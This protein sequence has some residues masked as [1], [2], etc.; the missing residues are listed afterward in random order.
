MNANLDLEGRLAD[1]YASE[2][3]QRSPDRVLHEA[4]AAIDSTQQRRVLIPAPWRF[5]SMNSYAKVAVVAIAVIAFG[6]V[7]MAVLRPN[8]IAG[9]G[10]TAPPSPIPT[11][12][13]SPEASSSFSATSLGFVSGFVRPFRYTV[14]SR[15]YF[16][17]G[18]VTD[19][20]FEV[21]APEWYDAGHAGGLIVQAIGGG[22]VDRCDADSAPVELGAGPQAVFDYLASIP[23]LTV[24]ETSATTVDG[25]PALQARVTAAAGTS[26]CPALHVWREEG[27]PFITE[28]DLRLIAVDVDGEPIVITIFGEANEPTWPALADQIVESFDFQSPGEPY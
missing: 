25:R 24:T 7:G 2:A 23:E 13:S 5:P 4:L 16:D 19:R 15:P 10:V 6:A 12:S 9:P 27:E 20:Y 11:T 21:R 1:F 8:Q 26:A 14:P 22:R 18:A 17:K 28:H 3:P